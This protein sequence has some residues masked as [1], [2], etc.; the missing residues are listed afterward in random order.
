MRP[1]TD[2]EITIAPCPERSCILSERAS[3]RINDIARSLGRYTHALMAKSTEDEQSEP[4]DPIAELIRPSHYT[5]RKQS[6]KQHRGRELKPLPRRGRSIFMNFNAR[7][8]IESLEERGLYDDA[9]NYINN[10][11]VAWKLF[12]KAVENC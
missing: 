7:T 10:I 12:D 11:D 6:S 8:I 9:E 3:S 4:L 2:V 5:D 1:E